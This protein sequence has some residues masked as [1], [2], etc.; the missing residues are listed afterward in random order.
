MDLSVIDWSDIWI[1][2][3]E[4]LV[5]TGVSLFFTILLGIRAEQIAGTTTNNLLIPGRQRSQLITFSG[6]NV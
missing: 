1:A 6:H 5:M 2:T 4:T 3:W